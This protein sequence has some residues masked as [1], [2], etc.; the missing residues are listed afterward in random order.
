MVK[1]ITAPPQAVVA[2]DVEFGE[3][4][5]PDFSEKDTQSALQ[6]Q[7]QDVTALKAEISKLK[8]EKMQLESRFS[9]ATDNLK[10]RF[11]KQMEK[12]DAAW[13][14]RLARL[15]ETL[16]ERVTKFTN[17]LPQIDTSNPTLPSNPFGTDLPTGFEQ[18]SNDGTSTMREPRV[19]PP[20]GIQTFQYSWPSAAADS[21]PYRR[22]SK[23][24]VP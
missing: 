13:D 5:T 7:Q 22:T 1:L 21:K 12:S 6:A 2:P 3:V 20:K 23:N 11:D 9:I 17:Q 16:N 24:Y 8:N 4:V 18:G 10:N 19:L 14:E 15:D